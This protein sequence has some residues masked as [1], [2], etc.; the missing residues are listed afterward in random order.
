MGL[1]RGLWDYYFWFCGFWGLLS[2]G[3]R[4][5]GAGP[6]VGGNPAGGGGIESCGLMFGGS[7]SVQG[8]EA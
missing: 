5:W 2:L 1:G 6:R 3:F 7:G 4:V 8:V